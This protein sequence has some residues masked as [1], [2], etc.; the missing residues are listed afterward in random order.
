MKPI[1]EQLRDRRHA[2]GLT[3]DEVGKAYRAQNSLK[4]QPYV[5]R[6]FI[7]LLEKGV[8]GLTLRTLNAVAVALGCELEIKLVPLEAPTD[9]K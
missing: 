1:H 3:L 4:Q 5:T 2:L 8:N 7:S 6:Q 9:G